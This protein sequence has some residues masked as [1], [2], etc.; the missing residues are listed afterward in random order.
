ML[1]RKRPC[2]RSFKRCKEVA[3]EVQAADVLLV[4]LAVALLA[5][6]VERAVVVA[7]HNQQVQKQHHLLLK[8]LLQRLTILENLPDMQDKWPGRLE[9]CYRESQ[10]PLDFLVK[11][12]WA[13]P[14][15]L[16]ERQ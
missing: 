7:E 15:A 5:V 1:L 10:A 6:P 12:P 14:K 9:R 2:E 13:Q 4:L 11:V 3:D 8:W 16:K